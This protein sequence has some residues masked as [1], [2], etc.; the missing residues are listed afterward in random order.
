MLNLRVAKFGKF[1]RI[2]RQMLA[3]CIAALVGLVG[4]VMVT[5]MLYHYTLES[6]NGTQMKLFG[7]MVDTAAPLPWLIAL[8]LVVIGSIGF[9][10]TKQ[11]F[12]QVWG[13]VNGE[14]E[15]QIRRATA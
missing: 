6:V 7:T 4:A 14:I 11:A 12:T 9:W 15:E 13:E 1:R 2:W 3:V 8:A 5:E 10:K